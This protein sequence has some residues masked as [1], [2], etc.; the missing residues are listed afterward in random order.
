MSN[1]ARKDSDENVLV[2]G[3]S[4]AA[5]QQSDG[6]VDYTV[7]ELK[8]KF[9]GLYTWLRVVANV[10]PGNESAYSWMARETLVLLPDLNSL[11][12]LLEDGGATKLRGEAR[13]EVGRLADDLQVTSDTP[14]GRA[15]HT[16]LREVFH[17][18]S[19]WD[20]D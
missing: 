19:E 5:D 12:A 10:A 4:S 2:V 17:R 16:A 8:G 9:R 13:R 6:L 3:G 18:I 7:Y 20:R 14:E 1:A 15:R 11:I